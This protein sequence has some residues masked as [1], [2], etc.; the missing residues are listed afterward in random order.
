M[1]ILFI[2]DLHLCKER[3]EI[4]ELFQDFLQHRAR[5]ADELYILGDLFEVWIG[6]DAVEPENQRVIN[7][8]KDLADHGVRI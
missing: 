1:T 5:E 2:S 4:T 6:D 3:P 8:L 7:A